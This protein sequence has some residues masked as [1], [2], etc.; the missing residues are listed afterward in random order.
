MSNMPRSEQISWR[1]VCVSTTCDVG[2]LASIRSRVSI[3]LAGMLGGKQRR[4]GVCLRP[5]CSQING[6]WI[7]CHSFEYDVEQRQ[8]LSGRCCTEPCS[9]LRYESQSRFSSV[10]AIK[11]LQCKLRHCEQLHSMMLDQMDSSRLTFRYLP[12]AL[13]HKAERSTALR[14]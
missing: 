3:C 10:Q 5:S 7:G 12:K 13:M 1:S 11:F 2:A 14:N 8:S 4:C 9:E 6:R